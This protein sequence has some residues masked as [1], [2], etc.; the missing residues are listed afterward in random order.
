[1]VLHENRFNLID[2]DWIPVSGIGFVSLDR[3]FTDRELKQLGGNS[4]QKLAITRLLLAIAQTAYTPKDDDEWAKLG[5]DGMAEKCR[6]YLASHYECFWLYGERPFLQ[7]PQIEKIISSRIGEQCQTA[8]DEK[9]KTKITE[10]YAPSTLGPGFYPDLPSENNTILGHYQIDWGLSDAEKALFILILMDFALSGKRVM[11]GVPPFSADY[12][13]KSVSAKPG[14]GF[15]NYCGFLHTYAASSDIV[16]SVWINLLTTKD[17]S[18]NKRWTSGLGTPPWEN[19]PSGEDCSVARMLK[20]SYLGCLIAVSRFVLLV[21]NGMYYIEGIQYPS[22]KQGWREPSMSVDESNE[23]FLWVDTEKRPWRDLTAML[24]FMK[25]EQGNHFDCQQIRLCIPRLKGNLTSISIW[26]GGLRARTNAGD[27]SVKQDDDFVESS[28]TIPLVDSSQWLS[29]LEIEMIAL[30][31]LEKKAVY[32]RAMGYFKT[33]KMDGTPIAAKACSIYWQKCERRFQDLVDAC[34]DES[35]N[36]ARSMRPVFAGIASYVYDTFC[37]RETA[38]QIDA[39][40]LN[41]PNMGWY[42]KEVHSENYIS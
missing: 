12:N 18:A 31:E 9:A 1:M 28:V 7:M 27:Q 29:N 8:K 26:S 36:T 6:Q 24:A 5:A 34:S 25:A 35:G 21:P 37:P 15:G 20:S 42:L 3:I 16:L 38:R 40:A 2:E 33:Q 41:K 11:K 4:I 32:G 39:W 10:E 30:E 19:M 23:K 14:P 13:G 17:I 22:H